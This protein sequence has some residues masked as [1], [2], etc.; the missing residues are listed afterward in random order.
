MKLTLVKRGG[1]WPDR[2]IPYNTIGRV[3]VE[4]DGED[5]EFEIFI[6]T[7]SPPGTRGVKLAEGWT[8]IKLEEVADAARQRSDIWVK[9]NSGW[10]RRFWRTEP[11]TGA[12]NLPGG[13]DPY[14][15]DC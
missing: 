4:L 11:D 10:A 1:V 14:A 7:R 2:Q 6:S 13:I 8:E 9:S 5:D 12:F 3:M 15:F